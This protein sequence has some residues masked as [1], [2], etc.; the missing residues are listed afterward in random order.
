MS[1]MADYPGYN[2]VAF[3]YDYNFYDDCN[4]D[5]ECPDSIDFYVIDWYVDE[6]AKEIVLELK[7]E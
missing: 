4:H 3:V 5:C 7:Q 6:D 1:L 2:V